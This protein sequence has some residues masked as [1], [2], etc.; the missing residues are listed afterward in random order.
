MELGIERYRKGAHEDMLFDQVL[1]S[2]QDVGQVR[3]LK[4]MAE[5]LEKHFADF[6]PQQ[7]S[8]D[9]L[10]RI[11]RS[12]LLLGDVSRLEGKLDQSL[13]HIGEALFLAKTL[14]NR[15]PERA[16]E[17]ARFESNALQSHVKIRMDQGYLLQFGFSPEKVDRGLD[18]WP[19]RVDVDAPVAG[20]VTALADIEQPAVVTLPSVDE[21]ELQRAA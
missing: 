17:T 2:F 19:W 1:E 8:A 20:L 11:I 13:I 12:Y 15:F 5:H 9:N 3:D 18:G 16:E 4:E 6:S 21:A 7:A 10:I 14:A